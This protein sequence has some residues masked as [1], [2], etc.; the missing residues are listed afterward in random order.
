MRMFDFVNEND[1]TRG[2]PDLQEW[3]EAK[4]II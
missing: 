1:A 3:N 4:L 2:F